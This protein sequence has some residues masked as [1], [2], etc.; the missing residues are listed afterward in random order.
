MQT[1]HR[2]CLVATR[3]GAVVAA[4]ALAVLALML[5]LEVV[6]NSVFR[7]S[8]P[9]ATE[10]SVY[11]LG[12]SL[13]AGSGWVFTETGHIRVSL[14]SDRLSRAVARALAV[15][16]ETI[17]L[18]V[19]SFAAWCMTDYALTSLERGSTSLYPSATPLWLPQLLLAVSL[20]LIC[21]GILACMLELLG[22][23]QRRAPAP[24]LVREI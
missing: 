10:Y 17:A 3:A 22:L 24:D 6:L 15:V 1:L 7:M 16:T 18:A 4:A 21:L 13:F 5:V 23:A 19:A 8:Q 20:W 14:L 11:L 9:W 12:A 2:I